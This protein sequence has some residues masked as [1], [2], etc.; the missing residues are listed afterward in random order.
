MS[1]PKI[2]QKALAGG[3][4]LGL[5]LILSLFLHK[6]NVLESLNQSLTHWLYTDS[7]EQSQDIIIVAIDDR[8]LADP[9]DG[10]LGSLGSWSW[11]NYAQAIENIEAGEP[12]SIFLDL[13]FS[14]PSTV[15]R[16]SSLMTILTENNNVGDFGKAVIAYLQEDS[17]DDL[18]FS[19]TLSQ[20]ENIYGYKKAGGDYK[21]EDN[22]FSY[23][24][25]ILPYSII[26]D[27]LK[28]GYYNLNLNP[29]STNTSVIYGLPLTEKVAGQ[30][31]KHVDLM[32]AEN[33]LA[34]EDLEAEV[35]IENGQMLINFSQKP[36]DWETVSF[37]DLLNGTV[38]ESVFKDKIVLLG[39]T[40]LGLH[41]FFY[42][43]LSVETPTPGIEIHANALQTLLGKN[44][45]QYQGLTGYGLASF[46]FLTLLVIVTLYLPIA[47]G[48]LLL[49]LEFALYFV[50]ARFSFSRGIILDLIWPFV[51]LVAAYL[52]ALAYRNF[53]EFAEKRKLREAFSHYVGPEVVAQI[54]AHPEQL[55][56]GGEKR[57]L[58]A[59][60]LDIE[61]FTHLSEGL[62]PPE[63]VKVINHYFDA[64]SKVIM[65]H[66]GSVDKFEGDAIMALFGAPVPSSDHAEKA[67]QAALAI[68]EKMNELN[69]SSG[70]ELNIR[71]GLA[72]GE[73]IVGNMGSEER[74][75]Y[76]AMGDTVNTAS[77]LEG[78]NKFYKT[79]IL[80]TESTAHSAPSILFR[81]VDSV[82]LK[83]KDH[84]IQIYEVMGRLEGASNEGKQLI[85]DW[86]KALEAYRKANWEL[87]EKE[88][89][90][91][92]ESLPHDG[93][94]ETL[95]ARIALLKMNTPPDWDGVW[96]FDS[97]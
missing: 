69:I 75:D 9:K 74:F 88:M 89:K 67:C 72:T 46:F 40:S 65:A 94:A 25:E 91:V 49:I 87:A 58:T 50:Y 24:K 30:E 29:D 48:S 41:D 96:H 8:T 18:A 77:R 53:T 86:S 45:L 1:L 51:A 26:G 90:K 15:V 11:L 85:E 23:A 61:N 14:Q 3:T 54:S 28:L 66:G 35:P 47:W 10:G 79:R 19:K 21:L 78:A 81:N 93:P 6:T 76:T 39:V 64:L 62:T 34:Q 16:K 5:T 56:L 68:R 33:Y 7:V 4:I 80:V 97:K 20:Y 27:H 31:G 83:G 71:I 44:Y 52:A 60:F 17:P 42:T 63:V 43:P 57:Q 82:C 38:D 55:A 59:F 13:F 92:L 2:N 84:P 22:E 32:L 73:A 70:Y 12:K 95:I 37:L 36:G